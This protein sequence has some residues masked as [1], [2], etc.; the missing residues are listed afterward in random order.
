MLG[1]GSTACGWMETSQCDSEG[2]GG[3]VVCVL[4]VGCWV[5]SWERDRRAALCG[6]ALCGAALPATHSPRRGGPCLLAPQPQNPKKQCALAKIKSG[7]SKDA[8]S[9]GTAEGGCG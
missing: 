4:G 8:D 3:C 1:T 7:K 6:A 2:R 5:G 9:G